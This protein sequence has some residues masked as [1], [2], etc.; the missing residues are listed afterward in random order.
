MV[1]IYV[2]DLLFTRDDVELL[3]EFKR[4]KKKRFDMTDLGKMRFFLGIEVRLDGI[5][6]CQKNYAAEVLSKH[7]EL[8]FCL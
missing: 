3:E 6:I 8:Q 2:D 1:S 7:R 5:F 4:S